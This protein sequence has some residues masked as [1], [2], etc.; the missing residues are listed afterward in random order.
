MLLAGCFWGVEL[1]FQ[2]VPGVISTEVRVNITI[3]HI[4]ESMLS[5]LGWV[6]ARPQ[7]KSSELTPA[8]MVTSHIAIILFQ[9]TYEEVCSGEV[10]ECPYLPIFTCLLPLEQ[11]GHT[12]AVTLQY[13]ANVVTYNDL[14]TVL[15]DRMDPTT[16]NRQVYISYLYTMYG[17]V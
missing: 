3:A 7:T 16:R 5:I 9:Q 6:Y 4:R 17:G 8:C 13:D 12:E 10:R 11:T 2:R 1:S 14:L 15:W